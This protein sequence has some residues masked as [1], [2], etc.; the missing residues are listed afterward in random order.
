MVRKRDILSK[1]AGRHLIVDSLFLPTG[2]PGQGFEQNGQGALLRLCGAALL[3][4]APASQRGEPV[5][6]NIQQRFI[7][8]RHLESLKAARRRRPERGRKQ[9]SSNHRQ[10]TDFYRLFDG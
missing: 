3:L 6:R 8:I 2:G 9:I 4:Q 10:K 5:A 1:I 7:K